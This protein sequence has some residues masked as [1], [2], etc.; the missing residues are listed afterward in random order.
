MDF[1]TQFFNANDR[2]NIVI[3]DQQG[4]DFAKRIAGDFNP[5]HD[6]GA[7]RFCIPGDLLFAVALSRYG[8]QQK[9][10]FE[11]LDMVNGGSELCY[12]EQMSE[13][14]IEVTYPNGKAAL[15]IH[16]SGNVLD[17]PNTVADMLKK[18][19][20]FSGQNFPHILV[21]LMQQ[22]N[23]MINPARPLVIY[24]SM[25]FELAHLNFKQLEIRLDNTSLEVEGKRGNAALNFFFYDGDEMVGQGSK[26]LVLSGLRPFD[27]QVVKKLCD[28]YLAHANAG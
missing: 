22:H 5:I 20:A 7:K 2:G 28:D 11:F 4:S 6:V 25:S 23:V 19:V 15:R 17:E 8:L 9:M 27:P 13:S 26:K 3:S 12:P 14:G 21:P 18:Y 16:A 1:L 10:T 24:E